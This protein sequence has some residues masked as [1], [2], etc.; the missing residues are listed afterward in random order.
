MTSAIFIFYA[1]DNIKISI[2]ELA[3]IFSSGA[4]G[5]LLGALFVKKSIKYF[6]RGILF[7][8]FIFIM[9]ISSFIYFISNTWIM[10]AFGMLLAEFSVSQL[11]I[12]YKTI[13]QEETPNELLGRVAGTTSMALKLIVPISFILAGWAIEHIDGSYIFLLNVIYLFSL[14]IVTSFSSIVKM[15]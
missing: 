2:S 7:I 10:L 6:N 3:L 14:G 4:L 13:R 5:G 12:H 1:L 8:A 15:K 11:V 9:C